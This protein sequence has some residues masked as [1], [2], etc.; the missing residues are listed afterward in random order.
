VV[1]EKKPCLNVQNI[2]IDTE[3]ERQYKIITAREKYGTCAAYRTDRRYSI[4]E[5]SPK[6]TQRELF[7]QNGISDLTMKVT[8][9]NFTDD[10]TKISKDVKY[11]L[12]EK[13]N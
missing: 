1:R 4:V 7:D 11:K 3:D 10:P 2:R 6:V 13:V 5:D 9:T 8:M 12:Y